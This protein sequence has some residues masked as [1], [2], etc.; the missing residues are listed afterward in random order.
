MK[1]LAKLLQLLPVNLAAMK[2]KESNIKLQSL[3]QAA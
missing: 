2:R 3:E 1:T